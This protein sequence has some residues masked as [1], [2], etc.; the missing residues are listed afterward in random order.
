M[1]DYRWRQ[2]RPRFNKFMRRVHRLQVEN[3]AARVARQM[4]RAFGGEEGFARAVYEFWQTAGLT[5]DG[6]RTR[7]SLLLAIVEMSRFADADEA[8]RQKKIADEQKSC[9]HFMTDEELAEDC[10]RHALKMVRDHPEVAI[11]SAARLGWT[12]IPPADDE[13]PSRPGGNAGTGTVCA[14]LSQEL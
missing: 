9:Y 6:I 13:E 14:G 5:R 3:D 12:I 2:R 11:R 10:D 8:G 4:L 1:S 7:N